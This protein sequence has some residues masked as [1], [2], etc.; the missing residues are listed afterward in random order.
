M[1]NLK[2][3]I[4]LASLALSAHL[5][6]QSIATEAF[7]VSNITTVTYV[8]AGYNLP[9]PVSVSAVAAGASLP[10]EPGDYSWNI[11]YTVG[12]VPTFLTI[13]F[14]NTFSGTIY[15]EGTWPLYTSAA[16]DFEATGAGTSTLQ[17]C[18]ACSASAPAA[19]FRPAN[20]LTYMAADASGL[21][22]TGSPASA[23]A[24]FVY[25]RGNRVVFGIDASSASGAQVSVDGTGMSTGN[26]E[27]NVSAMPN[28]PV[29]IADTTITS[30]VF[31][32][33]NDDRP[34][35]FGPNPQ[36]PTAPGAMIHEPVIIILK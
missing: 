23:V 30:G 9:S 8:Y 28:G 25:L 5:G 14:V 16:T 26:I 12:G 21:Q 17:V 27:L 3:L 29:P 13:T 19:R 20:G 2:H 33:L 6:A 22:W 1:I 7:S 36:T 11:T 35:S 4:F 10:L 32:T 31:G 18:A 24:V 15:I 34:T